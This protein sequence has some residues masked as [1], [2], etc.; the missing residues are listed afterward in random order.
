MPERHYFHA[1]HKVASVNGSTRQSLPGFL[2]EIT[3]QHLSITEIIWETASVR[4]SP[5]I[6]VSHILSQGSRSSGT[7][8]L[9]D[10]GWCVH[11]AERLAERHM[12]RQELVPGHTH[13]PE[14]CRG[15]STM[16]STS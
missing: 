9:A 16:Q 3:G 15:V 11:G 5:Q 6:L 7:S 8:N 1:D 12:G 13:P 10:R 14:W 4:S 2:R